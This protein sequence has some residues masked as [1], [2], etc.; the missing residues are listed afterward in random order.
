MPHT[1]STYDDPLFLHS[2]REAFFV[3]GLWL[4]CM[5][6][7]VTYCY[8]NGYLSYAEPKPSL[9]EEMPGIVKGIR[10]LPTVGQIIGPQMEGRE[11]SLDDFHS[12]L[13]LGI[14]DWV[15]YGIAMPWLVCI[16]V[17]VWWCLFFFQEDD[18]GKSEQPS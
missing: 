9:T 12:P 4:F 5:V 3:L 2:R 10:S 13:G 11:R 15:F 18:L 7:S 8:R 14:P 17:S 1:S 16:G 6:W